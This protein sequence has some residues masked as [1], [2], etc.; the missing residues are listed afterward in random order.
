MNTEFS[1]AEHYLETVKKEFHKLKS[2]ADK[3]IAQLSGDDLNY[4]LDKESNS[5][6]IIMKH[7]AGNMVS[8]WTDIYTADGE[9]LTRNRDSEFTGEYVSREK[10]IEYWERGWGRFFETLDSL[11]AEDLL[12]EITIRQEPHT[13]IQALE[14][15]TTHYGAHVGQIILLAKHLAGENWKTLSIPRGKSSEYL[16]IPPKPNN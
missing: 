1:L 5:I 4:I 7:L 8:R 6:A 3:S 12:R 2:L 13:L 11:T 9:K 15:Q 10:I 14:R 16:T